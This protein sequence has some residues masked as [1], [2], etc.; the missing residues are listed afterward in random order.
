MFELASEASEAVGVFERQAEAALKRLD[1]L[2]VESTEAYRERLAEAESE[3]RRKSRELAAPAT[4][5]IEALK[6][7]A[8]ALEWRVLARHGE[9]LDALSEKRREA[10]ARRQ[11]ARAEAAKH[12]D[13]DHRHR[14]DEIESQRREAEEDLER[15]RREALDEVTGF[16]AAAREAA[17]GR[18]VPWDAV[19]PG[20]VALPREF[21]RV[22]PFA[23]LAVS[24]DAELSDASGEERR[25]SELRMPA[26]LSFPSSGSLL[27]RHS[28][29]GRMEALDIVQNALLRV[30]TSFPAGKAR[31]RSSIPSDWVRASP[32]SCTSPTTTR[33]S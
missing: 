29:G 33:P 10:K 30:L 9:R 18:D 5:A 8:D 19:D 21:P 13:A 27:I 25:E 23:S 16:A 2:C 20:R 14:L 24:S 7:R 32:R 15:L 31:L 28:G 17:R 3:E 12:L 26:L 1:G 4:E 11:N 6:K 22:V